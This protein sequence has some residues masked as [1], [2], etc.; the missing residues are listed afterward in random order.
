MVCR[1]ADG[2]QGFI[3]GAVSVGYGYDARMEIVGT[4]GVLF[5][6]THGAGL[7][8]RLLDRAGMVRPFVK[9][10]RTLFSEAYARGGPGLRGLHPRRARAPGARR[11]RPDGRRGGERGQPLDRRAPSR[12]A[13]KE[14]R[15]GDD[16][17]GEAARQGRPARRGRAPF[18]RS[19]RG[20]CSWRVKAS[21]ICGTDIRMYRNGHKNATRRAPPRARA[22][23]RGRGR[24]GRPG[25]QRLPRGHARGR[26]PEHGLRRVRPVR[27]RQHPALRRLPGLR[28]Q[29][30]RRLRRAPARAR[31]RG[32][33]RATS[34]R[35]PRASTSRP[36]PSSSRSRACT[37]RSSAAPSG[38]A[39]RC[40]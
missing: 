15:D 31:G 32:A 7:R 17:G 11:R 14:R 24:E 36:P 34:A 16:A 30:R 26:G 39:T 4:K 23:D 18:P 29:H 1:F 10:W 13:W 2:R 40:S 8:G 38:P 5:V 6:G 21:A 22:R 25:S 27:E 20:R 12:Q 28:H 19:A 3:D 33:G 35:C 37:T 9:S